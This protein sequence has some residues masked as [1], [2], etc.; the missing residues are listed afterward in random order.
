MTR[1]FKSLLGP[2]IALL[3]VPALAMLPALLAPASAESVVGRVGRVGPLTGPPLSGVNATG[4]SFGT[5]TARVNQEI[6]WAHSLNAHA[7]RVEIPWSTL[8]PVQGQINPRALA[9]TD[10]LV[11]RA[12][13]ADIKVVALAMW[14]P[15]WASSAPASL[16]AKCRAGTGSKA[17]AWAPVN[18]AAYGSFVAF[19]AARYGSKLAAI[20]VWNE[21]DQAN[22]DY[23]AGPEKAKHYAEI[24][25]AAYPAIKQA[26]PTMTVLGG[27]LVGS[28]GAFLKALYAAG[29][30]GYYDG[31]SVHFYNLVLA[32]LR[33][34]HEVQLANGDTKPLWL[35]EF[36]WSSCWPR[37][38][39]QQEQACVTKSVQATNLKNVYRS[40][41]RTPWVAAEMVYSLQGTRREDF[42][43]LTETGAH[44]PSF[45]ALRSV[46]SSP[47]G[48]PSPVTIHLGRRGGRVLASGSGPV[49]D[50][51]QM[52]AFKGG[53]PV[54]RAQFTLDRFN[55]YAIALPGVLGTR[56]LRVT[57][58]QYWTGTA[59]AA[60]ASI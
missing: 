56:G 8:E 50:Y 1:R 42:G 53:R 39:V 38:R 4:I 35:N 25:R 15:C 17:Q 29:I 36:G 30:K 57:V 34:L 3:I 45:G 59:R 16:L 2:V 51:L 6:A 9:F 60:E 24:L 52:E 20:E 31:L 58:F 44:K 7:I 46:F 43:V 27:S 32:S 55:R 41:A 19:L 33:Y 21:P 37:R 49:G 13:A 14:T 22:E 26:D 12:A 5:P 23:L 11:N 48:K 10:N 47:F 54:Y 18:P 40:L 28:N